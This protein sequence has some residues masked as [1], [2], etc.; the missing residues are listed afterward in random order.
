MQ[1]DLFGS[2]PEPA[3]EIVSIT[4]GEY[5][6]FPNFYKRPDADRFFK[7]FK[8]NIDW[9]QEEMNMYG[10]VLKFPRLTAWYGDN[11]KPYSFSGITLQPKSWNREL[12]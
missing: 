8:N 5:R 1:V 11:E 7:A 3:G 4:N 6:Y 12:L 2:E 10:K 9:K